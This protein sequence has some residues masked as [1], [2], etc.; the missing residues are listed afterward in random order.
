MPLG[1]AKASFKDFLFPLVVVADKGAGLRD[2]AEPPWELV[3]ISP[4]T[5]ELWNSNWHG[6]LFPMVLQ[7]ATAM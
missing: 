7:R 3:C 6:P 4:L 2:P 1:M 5:V